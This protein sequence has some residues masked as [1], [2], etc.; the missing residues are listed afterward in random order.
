MPNND[1]I[2][3]I[4]VDMGALTDDKLNEAWSKYQD[5][6]YKHTFGKFLIDNKYITD[7]QLRVALL[8]QKVSRNQSVPTPMEDDNFRLQRLNRLESVE[9]LNVRRILAKLA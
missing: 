5:D 7:D 8:K 3:F 6:S 1:L 4:L 2:G 9:I